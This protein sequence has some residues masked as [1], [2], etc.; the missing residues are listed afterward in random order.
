MPGALDTLLGQ[1]AERIVFQYANAN[2]EVELAYPE[3]IDDTTKPQIGDVAANPAG[4]VNALITW[5]TDEFATSTVLYGTQ[6]GSY[7]QTVHDP[8]YV[9]QHEITLAVTPGTT[10]Y[11]RVR[12]TDLSGN[13]STS[14]EHSLT[15]IL[16]AYLPVVMRN[17]P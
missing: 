6:S 14:A 1:V 9:K 11:Y 7:P 2:R 8:L 15:A 10:Y 17:A 13:T 4:G 5:T 16:S 3:L 12:S